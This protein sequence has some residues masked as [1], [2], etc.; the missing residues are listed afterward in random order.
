[1]SP[2]VLIA[3]LA[4][5]LSQGP[6]LAQE[7]DA[8]DPSQPAKPAAK[9]PLTLDE[10]YHAFQSPHKE[11][12]LAALK[13]IQK[14]PGQAPPPLLFFSARKLFQLGKKEQ[15]VFWLMAGQLRAR[16]DLARS[17]DQT[18]ENMIVLLN[19]GAA[20]P[21]HDYAIEQPDVMIGW[22]KRL[23]D[24]DALT[25]YEYDPHW[26]LFHGDRA[27]DAETGK[28]ELKPESQ[29]P[30]LRLATRKTYDQSVRD[31]VA[32]LHKENGKQ[33]VVFLRSLNEKRLVYRQ[34]G[35]AYEPTDPERQQEAAALKLLDRDI[36][37]DFGTKPNQ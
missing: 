36:A 6:L 20:K 32:L 12:H 31:F 19:M 2:A 13:L 34:K 26:I 29:W 7:K 9:V 15:A 5:A 11:D 21:I 4:L 17:P 28:L 16:Y 14:Q 1:M 8:A 33:A 25:P 24:W 37:S 23:L 3:M 22:L 10:S 18:A 30:Q 27:K 35:Q